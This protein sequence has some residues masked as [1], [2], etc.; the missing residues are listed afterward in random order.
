[1]T[2]YGD[3]LTASA[4]HLRQGNTRLATDRFWT[5]DEALDAIADFHGMLQAIAAHTRRLLWPAKS[6]RPGMNRQVADLS[7]TEQAAA[8]LATGIDALVG[9]GAPHPAQLAPVTTPWRHAAM[10]LRAASD[11]VAMHYRPDGSARTPDAAATDARALEAGV[12]HLAHLA[13]LTLAAEEPLALRALQAGANK[14]AVTRHLPGLGHL[15]D[16]AHTI[17]DNPASRDPG[18]RTRLETLGP[19]VTPIRADDPVTELSDRIKRLRQTTWDL[20]ATTGDPLATLRDVTTI[21]IAIHAHTAAFHG[22]QT[23]TVA[24]PS[25]TARGAQALLVR[26]R[27]WQALHRDLSHF[28]TLA[29]PVGTVRD[30]LTALA[31]ILPALAPLDARTSRATSADPASRRI[32]AAL[33][34]AVATMTDIAQHTAVAFTKLAET[35]ALRLNARDLPRHLVSADPAL[36]SDRLRGALVH[37]PEEVLN[38]IRGGLSIVTDHPVAQTGTCLERVSHRTSGL[39]PTDN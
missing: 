2:T 27:A 5:A 8:H 30:D 23:F 18:A 29:P 38:R 19:T 26:G 15:S 21:G 35:G 17:A 20:N 1:M 4:E 11:L 37:P 16:L 32:G 6:V 33:N 31:R 13:A 9:A 10:H 14:D 34:G 25:P 7:L 3:L 22:A 12:V 36:A 39:L 28:R 24:E